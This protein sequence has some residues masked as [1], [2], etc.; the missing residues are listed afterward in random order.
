MFSLLVGL[1]YAEFG[2]F[3]ASSLVEGVE[4]GFVQVDHCGLWAGATTVFC[5]KV[6]IIYI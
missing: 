4:K 5:N 6:C 3:L 2:A 1:I